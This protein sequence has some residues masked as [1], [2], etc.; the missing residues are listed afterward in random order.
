MKKQIRID[1]VSRE[2]KYSMGILESDGKVI[3]DS[4]WFYTMDSAID[5]A[6]KKYGRNIEIV[7][8]NCW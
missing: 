2:M 1:W 7:S 3:W 4:R 8:S 5:E 6:K